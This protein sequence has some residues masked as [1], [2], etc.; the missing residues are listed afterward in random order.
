MFIRQTILSIPIAT[1]G[2]FL[3]GSSALAVHFAPMTGLT[4][5]DWE[6]TVE[7]GGF[8]EEF[9]VSSYIGDEGQAFY[10]LGIKD[11]IPPN[12]VKDTQQKQF[13]WENQQEVD[14]ELSLTTTSDGNKKLTYIVGGETLMLEDVV[15]NMDING[16]MLM[17]NSTDTSDVM[18]KHLKLDGGSRSMES[19][20]SED[21]NMDFL[22]LTG[23]DANFKLSGKQ[24]FSWD[25][26]NKPQDYDLGFSLKVGTFQPMTTANQTLA[27]NNIQQEIPEPSAVSFFSLLAVAAGIKF[28]KK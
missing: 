15:Q 5:S 28:R 2:W 6:Q 21:G 9:S 19:L 7:T 13:L 4:Q 20:L 12:T 23:M 25:D 16:M 8:L 18:L 22:K 11:V 14:F 27:R 24:V 26:R 17:A 3:W 1:L 10:E